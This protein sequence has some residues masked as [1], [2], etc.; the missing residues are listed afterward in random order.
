MKGILT[1]N[2]SI[3][4]KTTIYLLMKIEP[5][6]DTAPDALL[7]S[8]VSSLGM[9]QPVLNLPAHSDNEHEKQ[10]PVPMQQRRDE[11]RYGDKTKK[12]VSPSQIRYINQF[13]EEG[14]FKIQEICEKYGVSDISQLNMA[15]A[16]E[17]FDANKKIKNGYRQNNG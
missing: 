13:A 6:E 7:S 4:A 17:I 2:N 12:Q 8:L 3:K 16:Q 15:Q 5:S 11:D 14:K 1:M 10:Q 9:A